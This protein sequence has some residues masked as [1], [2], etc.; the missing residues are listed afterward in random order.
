MT[1]TAQKIA[2]AVDDTSGVTAIVFDAG[3]LTLARGGE[4]SNS[5]SMCPL[6]KACVGTL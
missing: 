1:Q 3:H 6:T 5:C 2:D 4:C